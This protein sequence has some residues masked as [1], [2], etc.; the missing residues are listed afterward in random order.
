MLGEEAYQAMLE[1]RGVDEKQFRRYLAERQLISRYRENLLKKVVLSEEDVKAYYAGHPQ[2][3]ALPERYRL[4]II[5]FSDPDEAKAARARLKD[6]E[7]FATLAKQHAA[8]GGKASRTRPMPVEAIPESIRE[9]VTSAT[10]GEVVQ[11]DGP[12]GSYLIEV[13]EKL[14]GKE[15]SFEEA[16]EDVREHLQELHEQRLLNDWY[17]AQVEAATIEHLRDDS[18]E[19]K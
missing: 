11:Y 19:G 7:P 9:A 4:Y 5:V 1:K 14:N 15:R 17:E 3:F 6:G 13:L 12:D 10:V 18:G 8:G 16:K 2:R